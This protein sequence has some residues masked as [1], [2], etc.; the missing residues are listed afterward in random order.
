LRL[1]AQLKTNMSYWRICKNYT[2]VDQ[3]AEK[4]EFKEYRKITEEE[5]PRNFFWRESDK[6]QKQGGDSC[7]PKWLLVSD[8]LWWRHVAQHSCV[9]FRLSVQYD[10]SWARLQG[11]YTMTQPSLTFPTLEDVSIV[12]FP[13]LEFF[14][15]EK[16]ML[17]TATFFCCDPLQINKR[18]L[19]NFYYFRLRKHVVFVY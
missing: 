14:K 12:C 8:F 2:G 4:G 13:L 15:A 9:L 1:L 11:S 5:R 16:H 19:Q 10:F 3:I 7:C 18:T 17:E 6:C